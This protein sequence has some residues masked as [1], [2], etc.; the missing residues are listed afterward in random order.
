MKVLGR[1]LLIAAVVAL[2]I[3]ELGLTRL[4]G[5]T[6]V[7]AKGRNITI[8]VP[9][10]AAGLNQDTA[11]IWRESAERAWNDD[12]SDPR[13]QLARFTWDYLTNGPAHDPKCC[14]WASVVNPDRTA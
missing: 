10:D 8:T 12:F 11:K 7:D 13:V 9:I 2:P 3:T 4:D 6:H 1:T 14:T 5:Q